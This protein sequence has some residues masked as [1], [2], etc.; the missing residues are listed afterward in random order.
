MRIKTLVVATHNPKKAGEMLQILSS[1]FPDLTIRTLTDYPGAP[2]PDE[3]GMTYEENAAIKAESA[4]SFTGEWSVA[5][6]AGLEVDAMNGEPGLYSKRFAGENTPFPEKMR[7]ILERLSGLSAE[8]RSARFYCSIAIAH[9]H[10]ETKILA[11]TCE[12]RIA[13]EPSGNGGFG[14]DPIFWLPEHGCTMADLTP[15]QKH[16]ISHRG[17][18]LRQLRD[19][20]PTL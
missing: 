16:E 4:A 13:E 5:D 7:I 15:Q 6:D 9:P 18:V 20:L 8:H 19:L 2:E 10:A 1:F 14:Y 17:K 11:A 3:T 12:G